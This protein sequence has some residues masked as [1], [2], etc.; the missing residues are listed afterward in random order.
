[1]L[2]LDW[3]IGLGR[4]SHYL[5]D[6]YYRHSLQGAVRTYGLP[7]FINILSFIIYKNPSYGWMGVSDRYVPVPRFS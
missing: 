2:L 3:Q 4:K 7:D 1:M 6:R 5:S